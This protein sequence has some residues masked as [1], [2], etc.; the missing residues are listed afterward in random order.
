MTRHLTIGLAVLVA[1]ASLAQAQTVIYV[2]ASASGPVYDGSSWC[3]AYLEVYEALAVAGP[4]TT[5]RVADG[6]Y[7]PDPSGLADP[8]DATFQLIDGV[9]LEGGYAGCGVADPDDRYVEGR[10][11]PLRWTPGGIRLPFAFH[12]QPP[13]CWD[14]R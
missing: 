7:P 3:Q 6:T 12:Q 8:R 4:D 2:D 13:C 10:V 9:A 1:L 14:S 5:I 11:G